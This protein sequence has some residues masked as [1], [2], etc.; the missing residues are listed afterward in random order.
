[1]QIDGKYLPS[2]SSSSS[3]SYSK[4]HLKIYLLI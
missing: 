4:C 3:P 2:S 1:L